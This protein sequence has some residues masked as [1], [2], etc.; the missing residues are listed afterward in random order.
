MSRRTKVRTGGIFGAL[1]PV[2]VN[3]L[4]SD[5]RGV[6]HPLCGFPY[7]YLF[8]ITEFRGRRLEKPIHFKVLGEYGLQLEPN[9]WVDSPR[10]DDAKLSRVQVVHLSHHWWRTLEMSGNFVIVFGDGKKLEGSFDAKYVKPPG[11][12]VCE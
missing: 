8:D 11:E 1:L 5:A 7:Q 2:S 10:D 6:L 12:F 4:G 9:A 3:A